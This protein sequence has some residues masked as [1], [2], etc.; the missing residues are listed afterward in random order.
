MAACDDDPTSD[1]DPNEYLTTRDAE[2]P[3]LAEITRPVA[4][5]RARSTR[6]LSEE[7]VILIEEL[8]PE[9]PAL[10]DINRQRRQGRPSWPAK[11]LLIPLLT[12]LGG[13]LVGVLAMLLYAFTIAG[14]GRALITPPP[15]HG[16]DLVVQ[17]GPAYL[18]QIVSKNLRQSG[19][20]G[21]ITNVSVQLKHGAQIQIEGDDQFVSFVGLTITRHFTI[22]LQPYVSACR[23]QIHVLHAD[24]NGIPV[25]GFT[26]RFETG[27]NQ[28]L[29]GQAGGLPSGFQYCAIETHTET[30]GLFITFSARTQALLFPPAQRRGAAIGRPAQ[31]F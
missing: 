27:I 12:F 5:R 26:Q 6:R 1:G 2:D 28:Q 19:L 14:E 20:P 25:T 9:V 23:F 15:P 24:M 17:L 11:R 21:T 13:V 30:Q 18:A 29:A 16:G 10:P 31:G 7:E 4:R 3:F 8:E 22:Q